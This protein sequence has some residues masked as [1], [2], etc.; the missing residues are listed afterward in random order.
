MLPIIGALVSAGLPLI[1]N[2]FKRQGAE[3]I[4]DRTGIDLETAS[5]TE[6]EFVK[7]KQFEMEHEEEL[8]RLALEEKKAELD[9]KKT[10]DQETTKRWESDNKAGLLNRIVRPATLVYVLVVFTLLAIADGNLGGFVVKEVYI[11]ALTEVLWIAIPAYFGA[12]TIEKIRG[13]A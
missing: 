6:A 5:L 4:K 7:L 2:V 1:A 10:E 8:Q 3:W 12:R 13:R 11:K 9:Y